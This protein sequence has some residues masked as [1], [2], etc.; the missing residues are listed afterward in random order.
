MSVEVVPT[1]ACNLKCAYCYQDPMRQAGNFG[2]GPLRVDLRKIIPVIEKANIG[3]KD[4]SFTIFGGEPLLL[5]R[6]TLE[7]LWGF[8]LQKYGKNG[9]QSNGELIDDDFIRLFNKYKVGVGISIDG[10][11]PLNAARSTEEGTRR[12]LDNIDKLVRAGHRPGI[13]IILNRHNARAERLPQLVDWI[14]GIDEKVS[15]IKIHLME[16]DTPRGA[17]VALE[18]WENEAA[19][20]LLSS[21]Q[22]KSPLQPFVDMKK[23]L[24]GDFNDV[25]CVWKGCDPYTTTAVQGVDGD[26][27]LSNCGRVNKDGVAYRKAASTN[28]ERVVAL[29]HTPHSAGGCQGCRYFFACR[30]QC[31]GEAINGDWRNRSVHC[32]AYY[33]VFEELESKHGIVEE[34]VRLSRETFTDGSYN[35]DH[36]DLH[37][38]TPHSDRVLIYVP[39]VAKR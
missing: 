34:K 8:G 21:L 29:Y 31:P 23:I 20:L 18:E 27:T 9:I 15:E 33:R 7:R 1:I 36:D 39:V 26:G 4:P 38:D 16:V 12:T 13:H 2:T 24:L 22:T 10:H 6:L 32:Q 5:P 14:K 30:G 37:H 19:F 17:E 35:T 11:W 3:A 25:G 28:L